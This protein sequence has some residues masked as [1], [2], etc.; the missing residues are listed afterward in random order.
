MTPRASLSGGIDDARGQALAA[1]SIL[2]G[3]VIALPTDTLYGFSAALSQEAAV[4]RI[5]AI[6]RAPEERRFIVLAS[7]ADM[8]AK[9]VASFGCTTRDAL[10][11]RW[12]ASFTAIL[13]S[14][15]ACPAWVGPT[16]AMRV[17]AWEPLRLLVAR[18]GEPVV[19]TSANRTGAP[20][21]DDAHAILRE[22]GED[23][24]AVF[25]RIGAGGAASTIVDFCGVTPRVVRAGSYAW[26]ATGAGKPSK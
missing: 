23:I 21:L 22:F 25:E 17:P 16:V 12:P 14:G 6:K 8:V 20:P 24:D 13:P 9:Y 11:A 10:A 7:S 5:A 15:P 18:V 2:H 26:D 1:E 3:A 19:S 4:R